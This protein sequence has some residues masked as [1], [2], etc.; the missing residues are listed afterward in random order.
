MKLNRLKL[1]AALAVVS[2]LVFGNTA[3]AATTIDIT[4]SGTS[5]A[6]NSIASGDSVDVTDS[7]SIPVVGAAQAELN[8]SLSLI[9][10]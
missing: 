5:T 6:V 7:A 9:H 1:A 3:Q 8:S 10:I 4:A 2:V